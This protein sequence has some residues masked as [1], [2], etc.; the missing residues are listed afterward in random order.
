[1]NSFKYINF[2]NII[3]YSRV[4]KNYEEAITAFEKA[5]TYDDASN[6]NERLFQWK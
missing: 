4:N 6:V 5:L 1:M 2:F 3:N